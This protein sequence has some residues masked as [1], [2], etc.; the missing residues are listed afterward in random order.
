MYD[1]YFVLR[2]IKTQ[3]YLLSFKSKNYLAYLWIIVSNDLSFFLACPPKCK[4]DLAGDGVCE[5][6]CDIEE[7]DF[8]DIDCNVLVKRNG[9]FF[10]EWIFMTRSKLV[11]QKRKVLRSLRGELE[12]LK[13]LENVDVFVN[14]WNENVQKK[15]TKS[16]DDSIPNLTFSWWTFLVD[17]IL[18]VRC[19][20]KILPNMLSQVP[21]THMLL[22]HKLIKWF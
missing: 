22:T 12:V 14:F 9:F 1:F 20:R 2:G 17:S 15:T 10:V 21:Q 5:K 4:E 13:I 19:T 3:G 6:A 8:V 16:I 18:C 11:L 7:C